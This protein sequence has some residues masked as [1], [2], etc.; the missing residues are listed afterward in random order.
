MLVQRHFDG[1]FSTDPYPIGMRH[2]AQCSHGRK[3]A[4]LSGQ[5]KI[6]GNDDRSV[7]WQDTAGMV[8]LRYPKYNNYRHRRMAVDMVPYTTLFL[9]SP[10]LRLQL[11]SI[12]ISILLPGIDAGGFACS[13]ILYPSSDCIQDGYG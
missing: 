4:S 5:N 13:L 6:R 3:G 12:G 2:S 11:P 1:I 8:M 7:R 10:L 9:P